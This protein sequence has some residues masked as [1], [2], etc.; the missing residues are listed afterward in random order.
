MTGWRAIDLIR[1]IKGETA[2]RCIDRHKAFELA[3]KALNDREWILCSE[4]MPENETEVEI[5]FVRK[6]Y[7]TGETLYLTARAFYE[8]GT[9]TTENSLFNWYATDDWEYD[10]P[11]DSCI[12]PAGW[13]EGVSFTEEFGIVDMPVIAWRYLTE[14]YRPQKILEYADNE[15]TQS[16]LMSAT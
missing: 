16:G 14:P 8:D 2:D 12:I 3:I 7:K 1:Q 5:T 15:T 10:E 4:R 9:L 13:Y 11:T 6:H